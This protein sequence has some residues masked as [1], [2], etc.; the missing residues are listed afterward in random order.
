MQ[1][2]GAR[3]RGKGAAFAA[4]FCDRGFSVGGLVDCMLSRI[5][6]RERVCG[7]SNGRW[8]EAKVK[9]VCSML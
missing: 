1:V 6:N 5:W 9:L 3:G 4:Y 8:R 2:K 7:R